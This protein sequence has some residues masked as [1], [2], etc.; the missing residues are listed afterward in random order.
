M[1]KWVFTGLIFL[2]VIFG[3]LTGRVREVSSAA[4][5]ESSNA[6]NLIISLMG[7]ICLWSGIMKIAEDSKLTDKIS[8]LLYPITKFI[9]KGLKK[10]SKALKTISM[11]MT[12]NLMGLGNAATPLGIK[13]MKELEDEEKSSST[14]TKNMITF[15]VLN[16]ASI[17]LVPT[18][19]AFIRQKYNAVSPLDILPAILITSM[20][21]VI[22]G[23][24]VIKI[25]SCF[26]SKDK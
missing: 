2:S 6:I 8:N 7:S 17:Q 24:L 22:S 15:V 21:S 16:T 26:K 18:T 1:M 23:L 11:N 13:A 5:K 3:I 4:M 9:F 10:D 12:A 25:F 20:V 14:A 19:I